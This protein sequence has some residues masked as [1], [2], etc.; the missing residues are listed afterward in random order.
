MPNVNVN[1]TVCN[2]QGIKCLN[3]DQSGTC[4]DFKV[5]ATCPCQGKLEE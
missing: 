3:K 5:R 4:P 2:S 1:D